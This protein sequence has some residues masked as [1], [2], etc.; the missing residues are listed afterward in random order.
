LV[1]DEEPITHMETKLLEGLGYQVT[2]TTSAT[3]LREIFHDNPENFDLI[4]TDMAM[5]EI[6]GADL[7][8]DLLSIRADQPIILC[9]GFS[10]TINEKA[11]KSIGIKSFI[12]KPLILKDLAIK[13]RKVLDANIL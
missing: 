8:K 9:T 12:M 11:A 3:R 5:P 6:N 7:A 2:A 13:V 10:D 4:I 1:D